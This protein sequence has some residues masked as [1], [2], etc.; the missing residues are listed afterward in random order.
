LSIEF[1]NKNSIFL[2]VEVAISF[3]Y[4]LGL[5][6]KITEDSITTVSDIIWIVSAKI[7][8][9]T[10]REVSRGLSLDFS[11]NK[12]SA[13][14]KAIFESIERLFFLAYSRPMLMDKYLSENNRTT[15]DVFHSVDFGIYH[16]ERKHRLV[17]VD[18]ISTRSRNCDI[19]STGWAI[20]NSISN[21]CDIAKFEYIER[22]F[23]NNLKY[24]TN[25]LELVTINNVPLGQQVLYIANQNNFNLEALVF[26]AKNG[27]Y[28]S[29]IVMNDN[30]KNVNYWGASYSEKT[31]LDS[32]LTKSLMELLIDFYF[33]DIANDTKLGRESDILEFDT[34]HKIIYLLKSTNKP[35]DYRATP[36]MINSI[37]NQKFEWMVFPV[38]N[39][40][41]SPEL[42]VAHSFL[43]KGYN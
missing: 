40:N 13:R 22:Y 23:I 32:V 27:A 11:L 15:T 1:H 7:I 38:K 4:N 36:N 16:Q 6:L 5:Q 43:K 31:D 35:K 17:K 28:F 20:G 12:E 2:E 3:V 41:K 8:T 18:K 34:F 10:G 9:H 21:A 29:L 14:C 37:L 42:F 24:L 25:N 26:N 39:K 19:D 33:I 30:V